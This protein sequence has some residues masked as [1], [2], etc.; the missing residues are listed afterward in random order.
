MT[1]CEKIERAK[2]YIEKLA[3]GI[4]PIHNT[5]VPDGDVINNI[6]ISRCFFFVS[7][8]LRQVLEQG[9]ISA[10][11]TDKKTK[12][13][14]L[15]IPFDQRSRFSYSKKPITASEIAKRVNALVD[16]DAMKK[17][18]YS[19]ILSWL[20]EIGMMEWTL[21]SNGKSTKR[22]TQSGQENGISVEERLGERGPYQV[23][24]YDIQA[25]HVIVDD[26]DAIIDS[27]NMIA[28]MQGSPWTQEQEAYLMDLY[29]KSVPMSQIASTLKRSTSA[30]RSRLKKLGIVDLE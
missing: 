9:G 28:E 21:T 15:F 19:G 5:P 14:P 6:R 13:L 30:V 20:T 8:V 2:L 24:V 3:N 18:T 26:L 4:D 17:L 16:T 23:V 22:P 25:Q 1:E 7:D 10:A 29:E 12:K 11:G 27:E